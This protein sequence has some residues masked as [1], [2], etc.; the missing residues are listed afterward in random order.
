MSEMQGSTIKRSIN[1][2]HHINSLKGKKYQFMWKTHLTKIQMS[3]TK[4]I[5]FIKN[6]QQTAIDENLLNL[7]RS[8]LQQKPTVNIIL[9]GIRLNIPHP[10]PPCPHCHPTGRL[11]SRQA[12]SSAFFFNMV[13]SPCT[14]NKARKRNKGHRL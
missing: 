12:S 11:E 8:I 3:S 2:I 1:V 10:P 9:N 5:L 7:I 6:S 4:F 14:C 13:L